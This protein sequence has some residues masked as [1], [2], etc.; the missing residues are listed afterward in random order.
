VIAQLEKQPK[1]A[2][3][4]AQAKIERFEAIGERLIPSVSGGKKGA[5]VASKMP[6]PSTRIIIAFVP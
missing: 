1:K 6:S 3:D 2:V 5:N 4:N